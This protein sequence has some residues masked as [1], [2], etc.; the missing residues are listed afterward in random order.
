[1]ETEFM[2]ALELLE[3]MSSS[4]DTFTRELDLEKNLYR[5]LILKLSLEKSIKLLE[6]AREHYFELEK[7]R[8]NA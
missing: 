1:M 6:D 3:R 8:E 4:V 2:N 7:L 5:K